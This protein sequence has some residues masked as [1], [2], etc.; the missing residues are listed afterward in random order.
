M[1][2]VLEEAIASTYVAL[3]DKA[4]DLCT[5]ER[6]REDVMM[7]ALNQAKPRYSSGNTVG[8]ALVRLELSQDQGKAELAVI[9]FEAMRQVSRNPRHAT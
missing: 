4:P 9:V 7:L 1:I 8:A 2:N 3:R 6:C 5:C